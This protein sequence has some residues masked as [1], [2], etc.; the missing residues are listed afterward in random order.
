LVAS[1]SSDHLVDA[2]PA[3]PIALTRST[4]TFG[5]SMY[6]SSGYRR[7]QFV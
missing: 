4:M 7:Q 5:D 3:V 2:E 6:S 1:S